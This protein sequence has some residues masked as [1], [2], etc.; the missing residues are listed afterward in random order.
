MSYF[1]GMFVIC[2]RNNNFII[3]LKTAY[4]ACKDHILKMVSY[5]LVKGGTEEAANVSRAR[6]LLQQCSTSDTLLSLTAV[7]KIIIYSKYHYLIE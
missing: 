2:F 4:N 5:T 3:S 7:S 1:A 6:E